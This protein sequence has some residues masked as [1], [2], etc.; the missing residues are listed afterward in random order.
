[1]I[2]L[3]TMV[4]TT[5]CKSLF[6]HGE[7]TAVSRWT[8]YASVEAAFKT[9]VPY[10]TTVDDLR[11][12]GFDPRVSPNV[13]ILTYVDIIQTFM[14]N[15]GI[16]LKDLAPAVRDCIESQENSRAYLVELHDIKQQRH[17]NLFLDIFGFNRRTHE[18]G[19]RFQGLIL[20]QDDL[21]VY[22]LASG[23]PQVSSESKKVRPL[24]P[25]QEL[26]F[27]ANQAAGYAK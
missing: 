22:K 24:G 8:N 4:L 21:V 15:P 5:G 12:L 11:T 20:I 14:P 6:V 1:M 7:S 10:H 27:N 25:L 13:K 23:E 17:G 26:D 9:I 19:W 2:G 3:L 18:S 16:Q